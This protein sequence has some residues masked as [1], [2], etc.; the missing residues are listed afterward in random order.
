MMRRELNEYQEEVLE[1]TGLS[2]PRFAHRRN[3]VR[4]SDCGHWFKACKCLGKEI[5]DDDKFADAW[6][7]NIH[8][9]VT[10]GKCGR[11]YW[12]KT[13]NQSVALPDFR[14]V[15]KRRMKIRKANN[16]KSEGE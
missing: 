7:V 11:K 12:T 14:K 6:G 1:F 5:A 3:R 2:I 15:S 10:C 4:C 16:Y 13:D 8:P 9:V